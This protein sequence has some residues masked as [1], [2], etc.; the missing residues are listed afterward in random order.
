MQDISDGKVGCVVVKD[1]SRLG[2]DL[3]TTSYYIEEFFPF[4]KVRFVSVN[5]QFDA[6][7][8]INNQTGE[9]NSRI[10]IPLV[11]AF[12]EQ[13]SID[14]K[15]KTSMALDMKARHGAFIG[16][17]APFGYMKSEEDRMRITPDLEAAEIVKQIFDMAADGVGITAIVRNINESNIHTPIQFA[18][19]K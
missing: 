8:G 4:K 19:S 9:S 12:N 14:T 17:R 7:D 18:R 6:V 2:R 5:D 16:P 11:N 15:R 10:R 3:I 1:L 13:V